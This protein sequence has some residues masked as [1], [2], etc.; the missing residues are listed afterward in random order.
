MN[1]TNYVNCVAQLGAY[2]VLARH[3][4]HYIQ[5]VNSTT[6]SDTAL[7]LQLQ[8]C[9]KSSMEHNN[10]WC[11]ETWNIDY[12][13]RAEGSADNFI[14]HSPQIDLQWYIQQGLGKGFDDVGSD[15][16]SGEDQDTTESSSLA[17]TAVPTPTSS[18]GIASSA[19]STNTYTQTPTNLGDT[20]PYSARSKRELDPNN[21]PEPIKRKFHINM[22]AKKQS[23]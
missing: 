21:P 18:A 15:L 3:G 23:Q 16:E 4:N 11:A 12:L 5:Y 20:T 22:I 13:N 14:Y 2:V 8:K 6:Y 10:Q 19:Y 9:L 1:L 7:V 17:T